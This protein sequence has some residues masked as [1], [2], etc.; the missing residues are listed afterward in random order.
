MASDRLAMGRHAK[1]R[2]P[3]SAGAIA[4]ALAV[5]ITSLVA[6]TWAAVATV[7][8]FRAHPLPTTTPVHVI[9][10][11]TP[12]DVPDDTGGPFDPCFQPDINR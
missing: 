12:C 7:S 10:L 6:L 8:Y 4:L 9:P 2:Q 3:L 11:D 1:Q 5:T